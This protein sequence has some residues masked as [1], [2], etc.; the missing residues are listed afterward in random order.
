MHNFH[1]K[2][3]EKYWL[4]TSMT[5][6]HFNFCFVLQQ[7]SFISYEQILMSIKSLSIYKFILLCSRWIL[8]NTPH[9]FIFYHSGNIVAIVKICW[10]LQFSHFHIF[11]SKISDISC[12]GILGLQ[13]LTTLWS[14]FLL[15][16]P[17]LLL[18][19]CISCGVSWRL[20]GKLVSENPQWLEPGKWKPVFH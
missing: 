6:L 4:L 8:L 11:F 3:W 12:L 20:P 17:P 16:I 15:W 10:T 19:T 7:E 14:H 13:T 2:I 1:Q 5:W 9:S 18:M